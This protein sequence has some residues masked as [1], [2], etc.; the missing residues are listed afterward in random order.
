MRTAQGRRIALAGA[1]GLV[2]QSL[3]AQVL[4]D[5]SV[6]V[7]HAFG[8]RAPP[9]GHPKLTAH[10][11]DFA[12]LPVLPPVDEVYL[13]LGTTIKA[14]GGQAAFRAVDFGANLAMARAAKAAG[15]RCAGLVSA[16]GAD[17]GSSVFYSRVKGELEQALEALDFEGLV[18]ARPSLL[19]GD[20]AALGQASR[21][22]EKLMTAP[23]KIFAPLIPAAYRA[24]PAEI[25]A[26]ALLRHTPRAQ[27]VLVLSSAD[28]LAHMIDSEA[29]AP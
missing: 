9:V 25:V 15:A 6:A 10:L 1:T 28:M 16:I 11:V 21:L 12:A 26:Q 5:P 20:R 22:V 2:G 27:G 29:A 23:A 8:R 4:A 17:V 13:A 18:M 14:A 3:L 24:I 19:L 7:V